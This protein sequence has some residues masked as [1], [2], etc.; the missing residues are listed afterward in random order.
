MYQICMRETAKLMMKS[1]EP[2][3][4]KGQRQFTSFVSLLCISPVFIDVQYP[5]TI[6]SNSCQVL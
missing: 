6:S 5:K 1:K 2:N 3:Q 4:S